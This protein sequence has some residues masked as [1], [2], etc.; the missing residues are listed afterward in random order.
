VANNLNAEYGDNPSLKSVSVNWEIPPAGM[1]IG[2]SVSRMPGLFLFITELEVLTV[3][4]TWL[5]DALPA[6]DNVAVI[7][8]S[9]AATFVIVTLGSLLVMLVVESKLCLVTTTR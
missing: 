3:S 1:T 7:V 4:V 9:I 8:E 2:N 6:T 5:G